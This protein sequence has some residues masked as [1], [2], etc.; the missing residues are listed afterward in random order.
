M[1]V[2]MV[3]PVL[4]EQYADM[5]AQNYRMRGTLLSSHSHTP[6][7]LTR[8]DRRMLKCLKGMTL[9][10]EP[11][12]AYFRE[13]LQEPLSAGELFSIALFAA[14]TND[15]FLLSGCLGLTQALPHLQPVLFSVAGW[16]PAQ[17]TLWPLMLSLPAC[18]AYVAAIRSDQTASMMFSQQ[19]ILTLIEQGRSVDYLLHFLCRSASPLLVSA[20]EAVFS[21]GR[22]ELILQGCRAVLCPHPLT[23][24]YT[25]E[26]VRQLLLLARSEK[27]DIRSCAVRNLLTHQAG[28]LG[29]ELSD[30]SD[31]RLRI[32]AM[33]WSGLPGYL[34][35]LLT[36]F[37][38]PEYARLSALS[39][40]AIT[41]SLPERD[42]W[43]RKRDDDVYSPV[44]A[45]SADIP[46]R[47]PEQGVGWP[48]RA[49]FENWWRT[50]EEHFAH[51]TPYLCGQLTSPEGL[52]RV[53]RQGYLN[54]R[55]LA[56]MRMG[57]FPEQ[58]A[59]PAESQK[60]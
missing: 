11:S 6:G 39:A 16:A 15:E 23:D 53:L 38:S 28:L 32:Q 48:E 14:S 5:L 44:S 8:F 13:Q 31:P 24:K 54:L 1:L 4:A 40:I 26:A 55:P 56:L 7:D 43:L 35:S 60:R 37:D 27:D 21:S 20:L 12:S 49:A 45:D 50:Q 34:P 10:K 30:L 41:G 46:A 58:A 2:R 22:D 47:D 36:Y 33:G 57:I 9:L 52:N 3:Q 17:S 29:S 51:D 18:R 19:E 59:L 42:G 25:G